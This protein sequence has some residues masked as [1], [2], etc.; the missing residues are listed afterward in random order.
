MKSPGAQRGVALVIALLAVALALVLI[1]SLLDRGELA[2]ARTRNVVRGEQ[3]AA[4]AEGLEAFAAQ[5]LMRDR[6]ANPNLDTLG[7]PWALPLPAQPVAG[8]Q[9]SAAMRDLNGC[10][11]LN[12]LID[13]TGGVWRKRLR[14]LL[15][16]LQLDP[17]LGG[18]IVDWLDGDAAIDAEG[19]AE[20]AAYLAQ[21][22]PYRP[23]NRAFAHVSELRLVRGMDGDSYA[24]LAAE[25]CALPTG[26][27]INLNTASLALL[28]SLD[29]RITAALAE[30]IRQDGQARW[31]DVDS[32]LRE[33]GQ[34]G[35]TISDPD[36]AGLG[37]TSSY[38]LARGEIL[39]DEV[40]FSFAS[41][42]ER[43]SS[44]ADGGI[45]V[46]A[47]SRGEDDLAPQQRAVVSESPSAN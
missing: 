14:N 10:F 26:S 19:G 35:V 46:L 23:G 40:P 9:I 4:Y 11:N 41:V 17:A 3:A 5:V 42:L 18:A 13:D 15:A 24:R 7:E 27:S 38:F 34:Q 36:R 37:V 43:R 1:A 20:D 2:Y 25:V 8:G 28:M 39:L 21:A 29:S 33:L 12:N 44:G 6:D 31:A 22:I 45:H 32:A 16:T 30:R 47:R